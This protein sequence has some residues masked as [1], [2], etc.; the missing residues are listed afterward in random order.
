ME[1]SA[2][3]FRFMVCSSPLPRFS[4]SLRDPI[5]MHPSVSG[6]LQTSRRAY[7]QQDIDFPSVTFC[8]RSRYRDHQPLRWTAYRSGFF[9]NS[10]R[11]VLLQK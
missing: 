11:H 2:E 3:E 7:L 5:W 6:K 9:W 10:S 1:T 4:P 8:T